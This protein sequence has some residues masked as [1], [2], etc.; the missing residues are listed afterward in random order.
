[1]SVTYETP[2]SSPAAP[3]ASSTPIV[4][5]G[6]LDRDLDF[7][8][9][10]LTSTWVIEG[11]MRVP[12]ARPTDTADRLAPR[13]GVHQLVAEIDGEP[14][15]LIELVT[16][17]TE[18]RHRHAGEVNL[19]AT[20]ARF[21]RRGVGRALMEAAIELADDWLDLSR[22]GLIVFADNPGARTLYEQLGFEVEGTLRDYGFKRGELVDAVV[23][24]RLRP[25]RT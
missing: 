1:M 10:L 14:A 18:P 20:H 19:V 5:R 22:L 24:S 25:V 23:M 2:V 4:V 13:P 6:V 21:V 12:F 3:P 15:G 11:T 16:Y 9:E 17:P 8:H 7:A